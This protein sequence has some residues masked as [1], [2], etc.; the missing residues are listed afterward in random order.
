MVSGKNPVAYALT[1]ITFLNLF[2]RTLRFCGECMKQELNKGWQ[3]F[4]P[5]LLFAAVM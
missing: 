3:S 1:K 4:I 5:A 2:K